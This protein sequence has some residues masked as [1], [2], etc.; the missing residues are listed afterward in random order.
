MPNS[1]SSGSQV[2]PAQALHPGHRSPVGRTRQAICANSSRRQEGSRAPRPVSRGRVSGSGAEHTSAGSGRGRPERDRLGSA[3][4]ARLEAGGARR[5]WR[6]QDQKSD[7]GSGQMSCCL[8]TAR[9]AAEHS[10]L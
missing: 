7:S 10:P 4:W 8:S 6:L 1:L 5:G 3:R 9:A 2:S